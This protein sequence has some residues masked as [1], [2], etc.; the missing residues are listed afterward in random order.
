MHRTAGTVSEVS[1]PRSFFTLTTLPVT[2]QSA[3]IGLPVITLAF[4]KGKFAGSPMSKSFEGTT[5]SP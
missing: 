2:S 1:G 5:A 3:N 4:N